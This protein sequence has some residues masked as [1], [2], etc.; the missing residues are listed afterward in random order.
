MA[1]SY[2]IFVRNNMLD[3]LNLIAGSNA[4]LEYRIIAHPTQGGVGTLIAYSTVSLNNASNASRTISSASVVT[5]P[6]VN[7][8][9]SL[10]FNR[11]NPD[12]GGGNPLTQQI[13]W[14]NTPTDFVFTSIGTITVTSLIISIQNAS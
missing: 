13:G 5:I 8:V 11:Y 1:V 2:E 3:K 12:V 14:K 9:R 7:T 10:S 6:A 4:N